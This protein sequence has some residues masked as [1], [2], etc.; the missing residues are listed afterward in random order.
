MIR[1]ISPT[2]KTIPG[3]EAVR[4]FIERVKDTFYEIA[5]GESDDFVIVT[6]GGVIATVISILTGE[7]FDEIIL[8]KEL[9]NTGV[10]LIEREDAGYRVS[11]VND[12]RHL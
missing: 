4:D 2:A 1:R 3:A 9:S 6:H 7:D 11:G 5:G 12:T 8:K 10:T